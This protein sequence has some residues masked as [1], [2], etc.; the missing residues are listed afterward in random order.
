MDIIDTPVPESPH[1][2]MPSFVRAE[3]MDVTTSQIIA[4]FRLVSLEEQRYS[5]SGQEQ[6]GAEWK[7]RSLPGC[8][9]K[10]L[11][12]TSGGM[13]GYAPPSGELEMHIKDPNA[14]RVFIQLWYQY[15]H[16]ES[17]AFPAFNLCMWQSDTIPDSTPE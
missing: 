17:S 2:P 8:R 1:P 12:E 7:T 3:E 13:F 9:V 4:R 10:F 11:A 14:A 16:G 5:E 6:E 15:L